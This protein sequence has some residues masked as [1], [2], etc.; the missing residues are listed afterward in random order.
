MGNAG[1]DQSVRPYTVGGALPCVASFQHN[2]LFSHRR[3]AVRFHIKP[4]RQFEQKGL[5]LAILSQHLHQCSRGIAGGLFPRHLLVIQCE[6]L[7]GNASFVAVREG[8]A[9]PRRADRFPTPS[10]LLT[11]SPVTSTSASG[12]IGADPH[13]LLAFAHPAGRRS[14]VSR[15]DRLTIRTGAVQHRGSGRPAG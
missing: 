10:M 1:R 9:L 8:R 4:C 11:A 2:M 7:H 6:L 15:E 3:M 13:P 5:L 14:T 12:P